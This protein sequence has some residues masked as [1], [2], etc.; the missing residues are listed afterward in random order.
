MGLPWNWVCHTGGNGYQ[1]LRGYSLLLITYS[2]AL[3][4]AGR[5]GLFKYRHPF[6]GISWWLCVLCNSNRLLLWYCTE[7]AYPYGGRY[8]GC[9]CEEL[10]L[11]CKSIKMSF[12]SFCLLC[13]FRFILKMCECGTLCRTKI[14]RPEIL[15]LEPEVTCG[16]DAI[17]IRV[18]LLSPY[19]HIRGV[20]VFH[21]L[22]SITPR[23]Y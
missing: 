10:E 8:G 3:W 21:S 6:F 20:S 12:C 18:V 1:D 19:L 23:I 11:T 9:F 15:S 22:Q 7:S 2:W 17:I 16:T 5:H 4:H 14:H 13:C